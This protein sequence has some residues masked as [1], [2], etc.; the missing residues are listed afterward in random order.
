MKINKYRSRFSLISSGKGSEE[1]Q[2]FLVATIEG[3][4]VFYY[5]GYRVHP[6]NFVKEKI[7]LKSATIYVQQVKNNTFNK[8]G[9]SAS[10][11]NSR[12]KNLETASLRIY[13]KNYKD[14]EIDISKDEFRK[15]LQ[16][17]LGEGSPFEISKPN[18]ITFFDAY[19]KYIIESNVSESR[20]KLYK[21]DFK[22]LKAYELTLKKKITFD[23]L[24]IEHYKKYISKD[25]SS[26]T[27]VVGMKRIK[28]FYNFCIQ[29]EIVD[30][31][32]FDKIKF[33]AKIGS[34]Q[35]N[36]PVCM[37]REELTHLYTISIEDAKLCLARDMFCLQAAI[38]CRVGDFLRLTHD[39]IEKDVLTYFPSKTKEYANKVVVPLSNRAKEILLKYKGKSSNN[40]L[41]PFLNSVEY[42][43]L[44]KD[45][46]KL[47]ELDRVIIQYDR[48]KKQEVIYKLWDFAS[49][50]L[51]RRTFVDILCQAGEPIH[52]VA[53][54]SG[55]SETSKAF[56]R[57]RRRPEQ[58][59]MKAVNRSMD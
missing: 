27:V 31:S 36:E 28:A 30:K 26:N 18:E 2:I 51:A 21:V 17:E 23:N 22:R 15:L 33:A 41:M 57:Y 34:E 16:C 32:P 29:N 9:D 42:N 8:A 5:S 25:R 58:L 4:E 46:F 24:D 50:H 3:I 14:R 45:I 19:E 38:G 47:A 44:L 6:D 7:V 48:D 1:K 53:S 20:K 35:Y 43:V 49:S 55:H 37:T 11:I 40:L 39:N 54:M 13:E 56:D 10:T 52:V 12:L 59:Q